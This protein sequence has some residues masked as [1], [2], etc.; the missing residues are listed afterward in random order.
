[1]IPF[2]G[3]KVKVASSNNAVTENQLY[4]RNGKAYKQQT[5][6]RPEDVDTSPTCAVTSNLKALG[7]SSNHH[8]HGR[9]HIVADPLQALQLVFEKLQCYNIRI[10]YSLAH[11]TPADITFRSK[12]IEV[13]RPW[14]TP[15]AIT[16]PE[17]IIGP[18]YHTHN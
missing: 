10:T 14:D 13:D 16:A 3:P 18:S 5:W 9:R 17:C 7:S 12:P 6:Y 15:A 2:R 11:T 1:M 8:L 4:L